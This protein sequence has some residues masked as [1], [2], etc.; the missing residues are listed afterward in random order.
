MIKS[1]VKDDC[2]KFLSK[3]FNSLSHAYLM[4]SEDSLLNNE[5]A[6][7]FAMGIFCQQDKPCFECEACKKSELNK[8]PDL[9]I[10]DK[11]SIMVEDVAKI[12]DAIQLKPMI[13][14]KKVIVIKNAENINEI[15]QNK[16]L[17]SLE[18]PNDTVVFILT[19]TNLDKLLP[20][21]RSRLKKIYLSISNFENLKN[22]LKEHGAK[23]ELLK[24][25]FSLTEIVN[26]SKND[27]FK[28]YLEQVKNLL[29]DLKSTQDIPDVMSK[30]NLNSQNKFIYLDLMDKLYDS[31]NNEDIFGKETT[32]FLQ[33]NYSKKLISKIKILLEE[34]F[35]QL[36]ANVNVNYVFD[37]LFYKILKE[38]YLCKQ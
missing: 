27:E 17:K 16:L 30:L 35:K 22:E 7:L 14:S 15:S 21:V 36:K 5:I 20:T 28:L 10:L 9:M 33:K 3:E 37:N 31:L 23:E 8:N 24:P 11:P 12:I 25:S 2:F 13:Y 4:Y 19:T 26:F 32:D 18:E 6:M 29:Y 38:K 1:L 34:A